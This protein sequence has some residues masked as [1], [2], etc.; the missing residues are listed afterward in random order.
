MKAS[1]GPVSIGITTELVPSI[2]A[3]RLWTDAK[4]G[5]GWDEIADTI[6]AAE[7]ERILCRR[8]IEFNMFASQFSLS[9]WVLSA[10][11]A[12]MPK[13]SLLLLHALGDE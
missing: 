6:L 3:E 1:F 2:T 13:L 9:L 11:I 8:R 5:W 10:K 7:L 12:V 4:Q